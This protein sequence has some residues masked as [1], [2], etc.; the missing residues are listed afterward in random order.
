MSIPE[1]IPTV[2]NSY[3]QGNGINL[4]GLTHLELTPGALGW[5]QISCKECEATANFFAQISHKIIWKALCIPLRVCKLTSKIFHHFFIMNLN[6]CKGCYKFWHF[7]IKRHANWQDSCPW[8]RV[9]TT[10]FTLSVTSTLPSFPHFICLPVSLGHLN[11]VLANIFKSLTFS[12]FHH[13]CPQIPSL[14][15]GCQKCCWRKSGKHS[16]GLIS[17]LSTLMSP[18]Y[19]YQQEVVGV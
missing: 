18:A 13:T 19:L 12:F 17:L 1:T 8:I 6:S 14:L 15:W 5:G 10:S 4:T 7:K 3:W 11:C 9:L 16:D 2:L